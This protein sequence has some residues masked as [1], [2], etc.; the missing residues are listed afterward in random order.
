MKEILICTDQ[1][2]NTTFTENANATQEDAWDKQMREEQLQWIHK[3]D[4]NAFMGDAIVTVS[5]Q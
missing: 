1:N 5:V 2:K 4:T 3:F